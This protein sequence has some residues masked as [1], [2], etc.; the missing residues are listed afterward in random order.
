MWER[1]LS[2]KLKKENQTVGDKERD[3]HWKVGEGEGKLRIAIK[4]T[5]M[6]SYGYYWL[7]K[8]SQFYI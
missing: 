2:E 5:E 1:K 6:Y 3:K 4:E 8:M 7:S